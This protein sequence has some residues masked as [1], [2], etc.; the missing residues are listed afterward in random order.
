[1]PRPATLCVPV[2]QREPQSQVTKCQC[3][4]SYVIRVVLK[5]RQEPGISHGLQVPTFREDEIL[6]AAFH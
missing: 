1:M 4:H 2:P 5:E 6:P 3:H